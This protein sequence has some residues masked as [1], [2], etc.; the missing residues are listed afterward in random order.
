MLTMDIS[1]RYLKQTVIPCIK[2]VTAGKLICADNPHIVAI[3]M[4][5]LLS[6]QLTELR[7]KSRHRQLLCGR[8]GY[9]GE[10]LLL[11]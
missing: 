6:S 1:R 9:G 2:V 4:E 3:L 10:V 7:I 8:M 5:Q 11:Q